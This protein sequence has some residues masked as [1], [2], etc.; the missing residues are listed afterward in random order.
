MSVK[1]ANRYR[2]VI[3]VGD[4]FVKAD[5]STVEKFVFHHGSYVLTVPKITHNWRWY[6]V[7]ISKTNPGVRALSGFISPTPISCG[8]EFQYELFVKGS[9]IV[10]E[11]CRRKKDK[12]SKFA[13]FLQ[14]Y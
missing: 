14:N 7:V 11:G 3:N 13:L 8:L 10:I 12:I 4:E 5:S 2:W 6:S 9:Q 1:L